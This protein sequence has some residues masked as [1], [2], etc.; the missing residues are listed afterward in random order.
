MDIADATLEFSLALSMSMN[1]GGSTPTSSSTLSPIPEP[2]VTFVPLPTTSDAAPP[3]PSPTGDHTIA[4][5]PAPT[6]LSNSTVPGSAVPSPSPSFAPTG[7]SDIPSTIF[8]TPAPSLLDDNSTGVPTPGLLAFECDENGGV[9]LA[10]V[11][12]EDVT[13]IFLLIGYQAESTSNSTSDYMDELEQA[14]LETAVFATL[15]G[16]DGTLGS[17]RQALESDEDARQAR[18]HLVMETVTVGKRDII[19]IW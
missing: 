9:S 8:D 10:G 15:N 5:A 7:R 16:C 17:R 6:P 14:L 3:M 1:D 12:D 2:S 18:R 13:L 19:E 11:D 4:P